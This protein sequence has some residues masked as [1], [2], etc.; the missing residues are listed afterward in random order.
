M[1]WPVIKINQFHP[2]VFIYWIQT[3]DIQLKVMDTGMMFLNYLYNGLVV[4][5]LAVTLLI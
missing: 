4:E 1:G 3:F 2:F 5:L